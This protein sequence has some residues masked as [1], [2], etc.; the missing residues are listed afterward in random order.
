MNK[1]CCL[2]SH[3]VTFSL[4]HSE[5]QVREVYIVC[6]TSEQCT[7]SRTTGQLDVRPGPTTQN[8]K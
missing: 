2:H 7:G 3:A 5:C 4:H 8:R 6:F 1:Y